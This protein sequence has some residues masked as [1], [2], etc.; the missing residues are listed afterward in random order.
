MEIVLD[1][2][3]IS[4]VYPRTQSATVRQPFSVLP[5]DRATGSSSSGVPRGTKAFN[6]YDDIPPRG[7]F[8]DRFQVFSRRTTFHG[9]RELRESKQ[10]WQKLLWF[11]VMA[12]CVVMLGVH[13]Q[14]QLSEYLDGQTANK[15][16]SV[17]AGER[18]EFP[19]VWL[20]MS[21]WA[22]IDS[23]KLQQYGITYEEMIIARSHFVAGLQYDSLVPVETAQK[24]LRNTFQRMGATS[25]VQFFRKLFWQPEDKLHPGAETVYYPNMDGPEGFV[26]LNTTKA[27]LKEFTKTYSIQIAFNFTA[28][29]DNVRKGLEF[30]KSDENVT[31]IP[32]QYVPYLLNVDTNQIL[33][34]KP[35]VRYGISANCR[36]YRHLYGCT[37][38]FDSD[39]L[40]FPRTCR[41]DCEIRANLSRQITSCFKFGDKAAYNDSSLDLTE[42]FREGNISLCQLGFFA[43][44][45]HQQGVETP[46]FGTMTPLE[47]KQWRLEVATCRKRCLRKCEQWTTS[48]S[49]I[50][51][52]LSQQIDSELSL[53]PEDI[54][55]L[56][57]IDLN[58][59]DNDALVII[60][61]IQRYRWHD[62]V[63]DL[64]GLLGLWLGASM[65]SLFQ[66]LHLCLWADKTRKENSVTPTRTPVNAVK[67]G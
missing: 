15:I 44:E 34:L 58:F 37:N 2:T 43:N 28:F 8:D 65:M 32:N 40:Y 60:E 39:P 50:A 7:S 6:M 66:V 35:S 26:L 10:W 56:A 52:E 38:E 14:R 46:T 18:Y 55:D 67:I 51:H 36:V 20:G 5:P 17:P 62:L 53:R 21:K 31:D 27:E 22:W 30:F 23:S 3:Y 54:A 16:C 42:T 11:L 48:W 4:H 45:T 49:V 61:E 13:V 59:P 47:M 29:W 57:V 24:R 1:S 12:I 33:P 19:P 41:L 25:A 64:G 9:F 63:S